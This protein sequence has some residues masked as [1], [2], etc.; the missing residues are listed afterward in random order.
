MVSQSPTAIIPHYAGRHWHDF[1]LMWEGNDWSP[2]D[3]EQLCRTK[4]EDCPQP[5]QW[6]KL[7]GRYPPESWMWVNETRCYPNTSSSMLPAGFLLGLFFSPEDG[8]M[9]LWNVG[10]LSLDYAVLHAKRYNSMKLLVCNT[11]LHQTL[12]LPKIP[13]QSISFSITNNFVL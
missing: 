2:A 9:F 13:I 4:F 10:W 6:C 1:S 8:D 5:G 7:D 11:S 3:G 12:Y